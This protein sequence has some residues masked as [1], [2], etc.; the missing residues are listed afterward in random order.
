M[1]I[2]L[3]KTDAAIRIA[4]VV[5]MAFASLAVNASTLLLNNLGGGT[6][7]QR[8]ET[9]SP[10]LGILAEIV[11]GGSN[12]DIGQFGV[13]GHQ[14]AAGNV[15]FDI[16]NSSMTRLYDSGAIATGSAATNQWYD[17]STFNLT[18]NAGQTYYFG[19][20]S[21]QDFTYHGELPATADVGLGLTSPAAGA[22]GSNG[23]FSNFLNPTVIDYCC[24]VQQS[25]RIFAANNVPEPAS[26]ALLGLGLA[27]LG[28]SRRRKSV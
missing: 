16:F 6:F 1:M 21:D 18:L 12:V 26:I 14:N 4:T 20:L 23:N 24:H 27:G 19:L 7:T 8:D 13:F 28:L 9:R 11:V 15:R 5:C 10:A 22:D 2:C 3:N 17:S 25:T